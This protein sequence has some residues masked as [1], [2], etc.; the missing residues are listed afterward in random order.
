MC[1]AALS[2]V[3]KRLSMVNTRLSGVNTRL[4]KETT[5]LSQQPLRRAVLRQRRQRLERGAHLQRR[6]S[7]ES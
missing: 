7:R 3:N 6:K 1:A 2:T 5:H 4:S